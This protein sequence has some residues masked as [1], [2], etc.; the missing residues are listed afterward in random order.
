VC[1]LIFSVT[2]KYKI[3]L[4]TAYTN[5]VILKKSP[6]FVEQKNFMAQKSGQKTLQYSRF[7]HVLLTRFM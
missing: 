2:Q 6:Y 5:A 7:D 4:N 1:A 3:G